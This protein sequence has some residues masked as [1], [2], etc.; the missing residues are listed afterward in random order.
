MN[1]IDGEL[2]D[3]MKKERTIKV[4]NFAIPNRPNSKRFGPSIAI[5]SMRGTAT[6]KC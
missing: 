6:S 3:C 2:D 1:A 5:F 4:W